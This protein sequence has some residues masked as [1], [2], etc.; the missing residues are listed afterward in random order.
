MRLLPAFVACGVVIG[1]AIL[2]RLD[3]SRRLRWLIGPLTAYGA[4]A[5]AYAAITGIGL[6]AALNGSGLFAAIPYVLRGAVIGAFAVLPIGWIVSLVRA[7]IP[8]YREASPR[9]SIYQAVAL[10]TCVAV[11][12]TSLPYDRFNP[13]NA[14]RERPLTPAERLALL[15]RSLRAIEDGDRESPRD[16]WDL[17][18]VV[19]AIGRDPQALFTWVRDNTYWVP[20]RGVLRGPVGVLM[21]RQGNSLDRALLLA[22]LL[23]KAGHEVRL[24][25][26]ELDLKTAAGLLP[27]LVAARSI[28]QGER[29]PLDPSTVQVKAALVQYGLDRAAPMVAAQDD[30]LD[31]IASTLRSRS[32]QQTDRLLRVVEKPQPALEWSRR[33][34]LATSAVR[35][36]WWVQRRDGDTWID[37][38]LLDREGNAAALATSKGTTSITDLAPDSYQEIVIRVVTETWTA[39]GLSERKAL[40]HRFRPS[41]QIGQSIVLQF[42]PTELINST[43][44][45]SA[46]PADWRKALLA[47]HQWT[48]FISSGGHIV[49]ST[50]LSDSGQED[51][52]RPR[53]GPMG[54]LGSALGDALSPAARRA[55]PNSTLS[56][57][58]LEYDIRVPGQPIRTIR[59]T[60]FDLI[61]PGAR[62]TSTPS[63]AMDD[64]K[65]L[66][67]SARLTMQTEILPLNCTVAPEFV[68]HLAAQYMLSSRNLIR[69]LAT[70]D[71]SPGS[72][73][74]QEQLKSASPGV[75]RLMPLAATRLNWNRSAEHLFYDRPNIVTRHAYLTPEGDALGVEDATDIVANEVG[76]DLAAR[77][78][79]AISLEQGVV[80]TNAEALLR[81]SAA[82]GNVGAAFGNS[83]DWLSLTPARR[84]GLD[85]VA[86]SPDA[87]KAIAADL[88]SG[89]AVVAPRKPV[90]EEREDFVGW[91]RIDPANGN[92]L[93]VADTGWG[94]ELTEYEMGVIRLHLTV[95]FEFGLC[96]FIPQTINFFKA[97]N[98]MHFGGWHPSWTTY[99]PHKKAADVWND[100]K[101]VCVIQAILAGMVATL[102]LLLLVLK[103]SKWARAAEARAMAAYEPHGP[104]PPDAPP[105]SSTLGGGAPSSSKGPPKNKG[106]KSGGNPPS[107]PGPPPPRSDPG[108][109]KPPKDPCPSPGSSSGAGSGPSGRTPPGTGPSPTRPI[110]PEEYQR[111]KAATASEVAEAKANVQ[112]AQD[113]YLAAEKNYEEASAKS[114]AANDNYAAAKQSQAD[115]AVQQQAYEDKINANRAENQAKNEVGSATSNL[116]NASFN[117]DQAQ[118]RDAFAQGL[119]QANQKAWEAQQ[120]TQRA[121]QQFQDW[122][123]SH[124]GSVGSDDYWRQWDQYYQTQKNYD[125]AMQDFYNQHVFGGTCG[126]GIGNDNK[127]LTA[128]GNGPP[129]SVTGPAQPVRI[130]GPRTNPNLPYD[131]TQAQQSPQQSI[132]PNQKSASGVAGAVNGLTSK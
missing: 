127:T 28:G 19:D 25:R 36:H 86:I 55:H 11:V 16:R 68:S 121:F 124:A 106:P 15:D 82:H 33:L 91:W 125:Q 2:W 97:V 10:T 74:A 13:A 39:N 8:R 58:R 80:D 64:A 34:D 48:A 20:Y 76:V 23:E 51:A 46:A 129:Q 40:E 77:D 27:E 14:A 113:R 29:N 114:S 50:T 102:P 21:D 49:A 1:G 122:V 126:G 112:A 100:S 92:T 66:T 18:Y 47:Q 30:A 123:N 118:A 81:I 52:G 42:W 88:D 37:L 110:S 85:A 61:G 109:P 103:N 4:I 5:F 128:A 9:R 26:G 73:R 38:D 108:P 78:G 7:G 17:Q 31:R 63:L 94:Q 69:D 116:R 107:D 72:D 132:D 101:Q 35:D 117:R 3:A 54:G 98:D 93:G 99:T 104:N 111:Y 89:Y 71:F 24:A 60:I 79:F 130:P 131:K 83:R 6:Q 62:A 67:R 75:S 65:R 45:E 22:T 70:E 56:A 115:P 119:E 12:L 59:R 43:S 57:V 96:Q 87:R 53:G 44:P 90:R 105:P 95:V 84:T 41:D 120:E 32:I